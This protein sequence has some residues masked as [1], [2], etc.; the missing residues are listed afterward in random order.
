MPCA[1]L[2]TDSCL[3]IA[4]TGKLQSHEH[5]DLISSPLRA[6]YREFEDCLTNEIENIYQKIG[7]E[8]LKTECKKIFD[9]GLTHELNFYNQIY[10]PYAICSQP[11]L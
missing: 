2:Y 7:N 6:D 8:K 5:R 1:A 9:E 10:K 4:K 11:S 3:E